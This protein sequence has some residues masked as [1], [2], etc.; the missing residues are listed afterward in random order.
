MSKEFFPEYN[1]MG[2]IPPK[3]STVPEQLYLDPIEFAAKLAERKSLNSK[4][5]E[6]NH[7]EMVRLRGRNRF[8]HTENQTLSRLTIQVLKKACKNITWT[9][10]T[11][12]M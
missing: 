1:S 12:W 4:E 5:I 10:P 6:T 9:M 11:S 3:F 8:L 2:E 7:V